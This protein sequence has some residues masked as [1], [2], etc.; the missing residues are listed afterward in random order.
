MDGWNTTFLLGRPIFRGY[1]SFREGSSPGY[2]NHSSPI[3]G[4]PGPAA[5]TA[6]RE[7]EGW[8]LRRGM[9]WWNAKLETPASRSGPNVF[10]LLG[11]IKYSDNNDT[12]SYIYTYIYIWQQYIYI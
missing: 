3:Q 1:V 4:P 2:P 9:E 5:L 12:V 7:G 8:A 11:R 6:L 10:V